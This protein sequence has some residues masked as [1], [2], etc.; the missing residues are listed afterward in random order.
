MRAQMCIRGNKKGKNEAST[1]LAGMMRRDFPCFS[2]I[3]NLPSH[4]LPLD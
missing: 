2:P 1:A 3:K 4:T